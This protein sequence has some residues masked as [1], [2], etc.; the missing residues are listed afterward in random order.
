MDIKL[1]QWAEQALPAKSVESGWET[2]QSEFRQF[3]SRAREST[4]HDDLFDQLKSAVVDDAMKRHSWEDKASEMLRVIQ[5]NTLEDRSVTDKRDWDTA[6]KF[7]ET[8]VKEK[9][10]HTE[11]MLGE[12]MGPS[13]QERWM[14][15]KYQ[16]EDQVRKNAVKSELHK[17]LYS[18]YVSDI[19]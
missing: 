10:K 13:A 3:M 2:L 19:F 12:M 14:Y 7:L 17:I 8:S 11:N 4:N 1:R 6:V 5:L 18:D 15:W 16:T 9:L